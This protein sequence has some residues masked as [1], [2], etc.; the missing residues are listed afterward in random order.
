MADVLTPK[1]RSYCMSQVRGTDTN[2]ERSVRSELH[3]RGLRFRK[4]CRGLPGRPDIVFPR[5]KL[6]VFL[7]GDF[8]HGYH[9]SAWEA[10]LT[11]SW[12]L[13]IQEN[14]DRDQRNFRKLRRMG[15]R[16]IR[17]WE[18]EVKRDLDASVCRILAAVDRDR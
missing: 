4:H 3:R 9:F 13:K 8:W 17:I 18:H 15:W 16:V 14:R 12:R 1:Q 5:A 11:E 6:A 10:K 7:D 2:L